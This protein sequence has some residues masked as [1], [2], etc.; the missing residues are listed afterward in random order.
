MSV[1]VG[2]TESVRIIGWMS[3][4]KSKAGIYN[5]VEGP[6]LKGPHILHLVYT[7]EIILNGEKAQLNLRI[8]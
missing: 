7:E 1:G 4:R 5:Q 2:F 3:L 8:H 6:V